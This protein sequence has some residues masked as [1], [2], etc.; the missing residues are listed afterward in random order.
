[1][2]N[3]ITRAKNSDEK[4]EDDNYNVCSTMNRVG[5]RPKLFDNNKQEY[6]NDDD[7]QEYNN[8]N[9]N[10]DYREEYQQE[11]EF[12]YKISSIEKTNT[13]IQWSEEQTY[14]LDLVQNKNCNLFLS[15]SAGTG[16]TFLIKESIKL[17]KNKHETDDGVS[18]IA[19]CATTGIAAIDIG[20]MTL[21]HFAG[22]G[23]GGKKFNINKMSN[24][25]TERWEQTKVLIVDE[26]SMLQTDYFNQLNKVARHCKQNNEIF[27]GIRIIFVGDF[28]QLPPV[29]DKTSATEQQLQHIFNTNL[30]KDLNFTNVLLEKSFRQEDDLE[31]FE[32]LQRIRVG[33]LLECDMELLRSCINREEISKDLQITKLFAYNVNVD[34]ENLEILNSIVDQKT[35]VKSCSFI[36]TTMFQEKLNQEI[37]TGNITKTLKKYVQ[38]FYEFE[39]TNQIFSG[40]CLIF[41]QTQDILKAQAQFLIKNMKFVIPYHLHIKQNAQVMLCVNLD[42]TRQLVNGS[43]GIVVRFEQKTNHPVVKFNN[44]MEIT[45]YPH[46]WLMSS[47]KL[48]GKRYNIYFVQYPLRLSWS[49]TIHKSQGLTMQNIKLDLKDRL[50]NSQAYVALSR[51]KSR[52]GLYLTS[53]NPQCIHVDSEILKF[54][55]NLKYNKIINNTY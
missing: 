13:Q 4:K 25:A 6:N 44:N 43:Q 42:V 17:L 48:W 22:I 40:K 39:N 31:F 12:E 41:S 46:T 28:L 45:I 14:F 35:I 26:I 23:I 47:Y 27:G 18:K 11:Q 16:K 52:Q 7:N 2:D 50:Q 20:G 37:K 15:G 29:I 3:F 9:D 21:H 38:E 24:L 34:K 10:D 51:V 33:Q 5:K 30:W 54:Y 19:I 36:V 8:D 55:E 49:N 32:T 1:M 53:F